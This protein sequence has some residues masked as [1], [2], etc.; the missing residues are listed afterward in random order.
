MPKFRRDDHE[1]V[2]YQA[3]LDFV[4]DHLPQAVF[5][6]PM[7]TG[8]ALHE[9][10]TRKKKKPLRVALVGGLRMR[11]RLSLLVCWASPSPS[12]D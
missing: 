4:E 1:K 3:F 10:A 7:L 6:L 5:F 11:L 9:G 2:T 8:E 12:P